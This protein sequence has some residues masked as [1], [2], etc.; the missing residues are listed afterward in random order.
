MHSIERELIK[1]TAYKAQRKFSDRQDYLKSILN[2]VGKLTDDDFNNLTDDTAIWANAA[3]EAHNIKGRDLPD[4][5]EVIPPDEDDDETEAEDEAEEDPEGVTEDEPTEDEADAEI[6][7]EDPPEEEPEEKPKPKKAGRPKAKKPP[8]E[9]NGAAVR[10]NKSKLNRGSDEDV[11]IDKWGSMEG[12]KASQALAMFEKG[13]SSREVTQ[14]LG[15][16]YYNIL[17]KMVLNGHR[18]EKEGSIIT[19]IHKDAAKQDLKKKK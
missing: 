14:T 8:V 15:G 6:P 16:T 13:A 5:D 3:V 7:E 10:E 9:A 11:V 18:T 4:F 12:S 1:A 2:A 17:K 19:L